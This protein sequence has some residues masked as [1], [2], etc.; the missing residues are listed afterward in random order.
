MSDN[1]NSKSGGIPS[2]AIRSGTDLP[3]SGLTRDGWST[4]DEA[5]AT[6]ACGKVQMVV[7]SDRRELAIQ[8][9]QML[10]IGSRCRCLVV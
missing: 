3:L 4:E 10:G 6:C 8:R 7:V 5:T 1:D 2:N 9:P